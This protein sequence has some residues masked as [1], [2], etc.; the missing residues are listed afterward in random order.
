MAT[1]LNTHLR[2]FASP[3]GMAFDGQ[4]L[5]TLG[6]VKEIWNTTTCPTWQSALHPQKHDAR[7]MPRNMHVTGDIRLHEIAFDGDGELWL[8][9]TRFSTLCTP[10]PP[11]QFPYR[12]GVLPSSPHWRRKTVVI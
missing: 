3:M 5:A 2:Y 12:A 6:T 1:E 7:F 10:R 4:R 11:P 8:V 9:N